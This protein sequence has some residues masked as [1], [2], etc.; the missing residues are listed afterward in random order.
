MDKQLKILLFLFLFFGCKKNSMNS[1]VYGTWIEPLSGEKIEFKKDKTFNWFGKKGIFKIVRLDGRCFGLCQQGHVDIN[2]NGTTFR[3]NEFYKYFKKPILKM[4]FFNLKIE[5]DTNQFQGKKIKN[6]TLVK[7]DDAEPLYFSEPI[8]EKM[9]KGL[10]FYNSGEIYYHKDQYIS[11][12]KDGV[13]TKTFRLDSLSKKWKR[14]TLSKKIGDI[15]TVVVGKEV[16]VIRGDSHY[17][18]FKYSLDGGH[19]WEEIPH[20]VLEKEKNESVYEVQKVLTLDKNLYFILRSE[21]IERGVRYFNLKLL[22]LNLE[23]DIPPRIVWQKRT[24]DY[25]DIIFESI[26]DKKEIII[27]SKEKYI[28][29]S[30]DYGT[31]WIKMKNLDMEEMLSKPL[32]VKVSNN[33]FIIIKK[34]TIDQKVYWYN[35]AKEN[36]TTF[37]TSLKNNLRPGE[38]FIW[39]VNEKGEL[40]KINNDGIEFRV[41]KSRLFTFD[42]PITVYPFEDDIFVNAYTFFRVKK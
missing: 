36:W 4:N 13:E 30:Q 16:L 32:E 14:V 41:G 39:T 19:E 33:E 1:F 3:S 5:S 9:D 37:S 25:K 18:N 11:K 10:E 40:I 21:V 22:N 42:E 34:N 20:F 29:Y 23:K 24:K 27:L 12:I 6:F 15:N 28:E 7:S 17:P 35:G 26:Q 2:I 38:R 8:L 31:N